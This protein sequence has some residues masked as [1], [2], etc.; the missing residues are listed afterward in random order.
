MA[1]LSGAGGDDR[2]QVGTAVFCIVISL[3]V[4]IL[5]PMIA[6][7]YN[8]DT[9]YTYVDIY[10]EKAALEA[11]TGESMTN[12]APWKL[13]A[14]YTAW[15]PG[16]A[17]H[18][19]S[20]G[21]VY[22]QEI[23]YSYAGVNGTTQIGDTKN[24]Y[25]NPGQ[26]SD[27]YL[28]QVNQ[29]V[30]I[31][32]VGYPSWALGLNGELNVFGHLAVDVFHQNI[33]TSWTET[34]NVDTWS[35][36]GYRYVFNPMLK[37]DWTD[38][39]DRGK[40]YTVSSQQD[41]RLSIVWYKNE[42]LGQGLSSG[43]VL[44]NDTTHGIVD[45]LDVKEIVNRYN[46]TSSYSSRYAL[47][48]DGVKV[49]INIKFDQDVVAGGMDLT[50]AFDAGKWSLAVTAQS[51]DNFLDLKN[52]N[53]LSSSAASIIDTYRMIFTFSMPEVPL[54]WS[55]VLWILCILPVEVVMLMFLS[56]FGI[57]GVGLGILGNVLLSIG[58][59]V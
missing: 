45:N 14:V 37:I 30:E 6:P 51:M 13:E 16:D 49:Y 29:D 57:L 40:D 25:L 56:R 11:Y 10:T 2:L 46:Y 31:R 20:S 39:E 8:S 18:T 52:S 42:N 22:G 15:S 26:K 9:G 53:S 23:A 54:V 36:S 1:L 38:P 12:M 34:K 58:L 33:L 50:E 41:A 28:A 19:D 44:W 47:D 21:W 17:I 4:T 27:T 3:V 55:M 7:S 48:Y 43:L 24:I 5:V 35:F 32:I 59:G